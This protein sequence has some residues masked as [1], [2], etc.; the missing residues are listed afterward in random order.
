MSKAGRKI[1]STEE[2]SRLSSTYLSQGRKQED[3]EIT[4]LEIDD[5]VLNARIRMRTRYI[6]PT[7]PGG[8]HLTI[9]STLE[10]LSQLAIIYVHVWAGLT[11]KTR[12]GW[13][14]ECS[15]NS[16]QAIRDPENIQVRMEIPSIRN[17]KNKIIVVAE[18]RVFDQDGL[19]EAR[20]KCILS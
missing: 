8:F 19:F 15:V 20:M 5:N 10:F 3:W 13:M 2:I 1:L 12:E 18:S 16:K 11:E 17:I 4:Y 7:D 14:L 6:S 9:F